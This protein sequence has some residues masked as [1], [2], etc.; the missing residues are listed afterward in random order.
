MSIF[1]HDCIEGQQNKHINKK[2]QTEQYKHFQKNLH[3]LIIE[4][5]WTQKAL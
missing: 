4:Y 3:T 1:I 5:K 2:I